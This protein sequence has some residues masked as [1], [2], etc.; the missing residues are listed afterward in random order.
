MAGCPSTPEPAPV[1][2]DD[3]YNACGAD[4]KLGLVEIAQ[5]I[6]LLILSSAY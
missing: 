2:P 3:P 4:I 5:K 6:L 1:G